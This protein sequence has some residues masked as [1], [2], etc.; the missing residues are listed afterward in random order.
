MTIAP[1]TDIEI[2]TSLTVNYFFPAVFT[3]NANFITVGDDLQMTG[4]TGAAQYDL[5]GT[6]IM[7]GAGAGNSTSSIRNQSDGAIH[8][9]LNNLVINSN[10][11]TSYPQFE[12]SSG[13][14]TIKIKGDFTIQNANIARPVRLFGNTYHIEGNYS[15]IHENR[16]S[17]GTSTLVF[18][19]IENQTITC[20]GGEVYSNFEIDKAT[21]DLELESD[22]TINGQGTFTSGLIHTGEHILKFG[23][24]SGAVSASQSSYV[25]GRVRK[26]GFTEDVPFIFPVGDFQAGTNGWSVFQPAELETEATDATVSF[27]VQYHH[28]NFNPI[29]PLPFNPPTAGMGSVSTCNYWDIDRTSGTLEAMVGLSWNEAHCFE[30]SEPEALLVARYSAIAGDWSEAGSSLGS[31][32]EYSPGPPFTTG[33]VRTEFPVVDFS[34]FAIG[35]IGAGANVLPIELLEFSVRIESS[36]LIMTRWTTLSEINNDFFTVER[37]ANALDWEA[38]GNLPGAGN[39]HSSRQYQLADD[40][41]ISGR[42]YYRLKQT[43][44][45]GSYAYSQIETVFLGALEGLEIIHLFRSATGLELGYH[46]E[47]GEITI[48]IYDV[49]GK[50]VF[51]HR[52]SNGNAALRLSPNLTQ[53]IYLLRISNSKNAVTKKFFY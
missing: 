31:T 37:S 35:N 22:L 47:L 42:S 15:N 8:A 10:S 44:Y 50:R 1:N 43:D 14:A 40:A 30:V 52:E 27:D 41:P 6:I 32:H 23:P 18:D 33:W 53:G 38:V 12:P 25:N 36:Q 26:T 4:S 34:P 46:S 7:T 45:D 2:R 20:P 5:T 11:S 3:D 16:L 49:S 24:A 39:S 48:E 19:G 13:N 9:E 28:E 51:L 21:S 17:E 29:F